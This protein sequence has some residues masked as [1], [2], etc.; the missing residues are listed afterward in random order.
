M[1]QY[2]TNLSLS[3]PPLCPSHCPL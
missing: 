2:P 3:H 1:R